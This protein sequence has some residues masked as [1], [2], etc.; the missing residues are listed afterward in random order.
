MKN[1][2]TNQVTVILWKAIRWISLAVMLIV[3]VFGMLYEIL[4]YPVWE[5][6]VAKFGISDGIRF[7]WIASAC[8]VAVFLLSLWAERWDPRRQSANSDAEPQGR[9]PQ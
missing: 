9:K 2:R 6:L 3:S 8:G 7:F 5:R 4:D 1:E